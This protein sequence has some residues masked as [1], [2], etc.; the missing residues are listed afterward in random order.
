MR[1]PSCQECLGFALVVLVCC[2][3]YQQWCINKLTS[4]VDKLALSQSSASHK[5]DDVLILATV[6]LRL[7]QKTDLR[8]LESARGWL[9]LRKPRVRGL[10]FDLESK[11]HHVALTGLWFVH[12]APLHTPRCGWQMW[13]RAAEGSYRD[14]QGPEGWEY[15]CGGFSTFHFVDAHCLLSRPILI[16]PGGK[17][18]F[19]LYSHCDD[20]LLV[21]DAYYDA[22]AEDGAV[23]VRPGGHSYSPTGFHTEAEHGQF[24]FYGRVQY[25]V[26]RAMTATV[27]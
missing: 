19:Y 1:G 10:M 5:S 3:G 13:A 11:G 27:Q 6:A 2:V 22:P 26:L 25:T 24:D 8:E 17:R 9:P 14:Q 21:R 23:V 12:R 15:I 18:A 20:G 16:P 7:V 4:I